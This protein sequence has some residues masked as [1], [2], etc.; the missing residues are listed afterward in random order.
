LTER[1][2]A[3]SINLEEYIGT[4]ECSSGGKLFQAGK[5]NLSA[6]NSALRGD[7]QNFAVFRRKTA[8]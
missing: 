1:K 5:E 4:D 6:V 2:I 3:G 7:R 8:E